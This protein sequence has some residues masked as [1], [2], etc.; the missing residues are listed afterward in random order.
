MQ[1]IKRA[2]KY[3]SQI[4][5]IDDTGSYTYTQLL[6]ASAVIAEMLLTHNNLT[7]KDLNEDRVAFLAPSGFEY[8]AMQ[9]GI[10]RAGGIAVPLCTVHPTAEM[11]YVVQDSQA[12]ILLMSVTFKEQAQQLAQDKNLFLL[13][14]PSFHKQT[15]KSQPLPTLTDNRRAM[16]LYTSGT[17]GKPKGVVSTH[18]N[19]N[20]QIQAL[21]NAWG[22]NSSDHILH[23]LPLHHV[24]GIVNKLCCALWSGATCEFLAKFDVATVWQR[25]E[26]Q[27]ISVFMAVPT[28]Y[29]RL[30]SHWEKASLEQQQKWSAACQKMRLMVSG[31]AAL[32]VP[33]L[34][35]WQ[36]ISGHFLLERYGMTEI[37]MA[38]SNSY[39]GKRW[40]GKVGQAL[41]GV[42]LRIVDE[43]GQT[44][45]SGQ[46]GELQVKGTSVF[47]E[48]WNRP[49]ATAIAFQD[50]WFKTGDRVLEQDGIY[51]I[52]G[53]ISVDIIKTGGYKVSALEIESVLLQHPAIHSCAVVGVPCEQW[54]E[55]IAAAIIL[56]AN[57]QG[58]TLTIKELREWCRPYLAPYKIPHQLR[59]LDELPRNVMGKVTK[60][61]VQ[62]LM[63][64]L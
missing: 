8:V 25:F 50:A 23:I 2:E 19:L 44:L 58:K 32:P 14:T 24:H 11:R 15:L 6:E 21:V 35:K 33:T 40:A 22:W 49:E 36:A 57:Y 64:D 28:I 59:Y 18:G 3:L 5:I 52:L 46:A 60:R 17:T 48:Y 55:C 51:Q 54:G 31:S 62:E 26:K 7:V 47:L 30:I 56:P 61:R 1:L 45:P 42:Q 10:W 16:I 38:L 9:W 27:P 13:F 39:E 12:S 53:R 29:K 20:A 34:K 4:A 63:V 41:P 43:K 37:G